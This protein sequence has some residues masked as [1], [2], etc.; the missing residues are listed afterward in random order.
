MCIHASHAG[1]LNC[2]YKFDFKT[3]I[4]VGTFKTGNEN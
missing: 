3:S 1:S 2:A 4:R